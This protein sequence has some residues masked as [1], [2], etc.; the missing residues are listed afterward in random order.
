MQPEVWRQIEDLFHAAMMRP[1]EARAA[2]LEDSCSDERVRREVWSLLDAASGA[3][4]FLE[5]PAVAVLSSP[6]FM[7]GA[8][9]GNF[10]IIELVG[11]GGM[12]EVYRAHDLRLDRDVAIKV[13]PEAF[14]RDQRRV[15]RL[16]REAQMLAALNHANIAGIY[17]LAEPHGHCLLVLEFVPGETLAERIRR[18]PLPLEE[19]L[20]VFRQIAQ[21][22]ET[23]HGNRV[24]HRDL[25]PS[26]VKVTPNGQVKLLDFGLAKAERRAAAEGSDF[27]QS[28]AI[29]GTPAYMSP[30]QARGLPLDERSDIWSFGCLLYEAFTADRVF[31][32]DSS[33]EIIAAILRDRPALAFPKNVPRRIRLLVEKCLERDVNRRLEN[34][35]H[36][37]LAIEE[38]LRNTP[39]ERI[40]TRRPARIGRKTIFPAAATVLALFGAYIA[41]RFIRSAEAQKPSE[42]F[43]HARIIRVTSSGQASDSAI[44]PDGKYVAYVQ[45]D[46]LRLRKLDTESDLEIAPPISAH[47]RNLTFSPDGQRLYYVQQNGDVYAIPMLG[48]MARKITSTLWDECDRISFSPRGDE[49]VFAGYDDAAGKVDLLVARSDGSYERRIAL[50]RFPR[51]LDYPA[52]SP[53]GDI[54]AYASTPKGY[55]RWDLVTQ[56]ARSGAPAR[57]FTPYA[58]SGDLE[59]QW[60]DKGAALVFSAQDRTRSD[61]QIWTITYP[62]GV[63]R[64][65]TNDLDAYAGLSVS[66]DSRTLV[67]TRVQ[68]AT[69]LWL[70]PAPS[71]HMAARPVTSR[72]ITLDG[73]D[74]LTWTPDNRII[75]SSFASGSRELWM[76]DPASQHSRRLTDGILAKDACVSHK[77]DFVL[78]ASGRNGGSDFWRMALDGRDLRQVTSGDSDLEADLSSD[79]KWIVYVSLKSG[80]RVLHKV[81]ID[82]G[83]DTILSRVPVY[84]YPPAISPDDR[85][86]AFAF[87]DQGRH[88]DWLGVIPFS[89]GEPI[90]TFEIPG[91]SMVEWTRDGKGLTYIASRDGVDNLWVQPF[92]G[93]PPRQITNFS[94]GRIFRFAWRPDSKL[95]A[96][97]RGEETS[98][99]VAFERTD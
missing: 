35:S 76:L 13:L 62:A 75:F 40:A 89:G 18:G 19:A 49:F 93:G 39:S 20:P 54:I 33:S 23:A 86:V 80:K 21:A 46:S 55:F 96:I 17:D 22:L 92:A 24:I 50:A 5:N 74:A 77:G 83:R 7:R 52:W 16:R 58:W 68:R 34:I 65:V 29:L 88:G 15:A 4:S 42:A 79:D 56:A 3:T 94:D 87:Q 81:S 72:T 1:P 78:F 37:R 41:F 59:S 84:F 14:A 8:R 12:G 91:I 60:I 48:G 10:E 32:G 51:Y 43:Q 31:A 30:E 98:D 26:N 2:F 97:A 44:S 9:L 66:A 85:L 47:P 95:L 36:A 71:Q 69:A 57:V 6:A 73:Y 28:G 99:I 27:T 64:R 67:T 61:R 11:R 70:V 63:L 45:R 53:H 82:G 90:A 38:C 25:K